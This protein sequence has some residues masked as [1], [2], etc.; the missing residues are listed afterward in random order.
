MPTKDE[1]WEAERRKEREQQTL[2]PADKEEKEDE[3]ME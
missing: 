1:I 2:F 3:D